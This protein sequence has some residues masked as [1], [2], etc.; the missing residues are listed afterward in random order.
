MGINVKDPEALAG[1]SATGSMQFGQSIKSQ[2]YRDRA[3]AASILCRV[4]SDCHS[5][6]A[7][8]ILY[9]VLDSYHR[10]GMPVSPRRNLM[11]Y[12]V[13]WASWA[14]EHELRAYAVAAARRMSPATREAFRVYL[15]GGGA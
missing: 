11:A 5:E 3:E 13:D 12:A 8:P 9:A 1:A 14:N 10:D 6:D 7:A 2:E 15:Q 4:I